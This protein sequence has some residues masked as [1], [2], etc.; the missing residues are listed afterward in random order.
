MAAQ[1]TGCAPTQVP[2]WQV[3]VRVQASASSQAVPSATAS[4]GMQVPVA[5]SQVLAVWHWSG[6]AGQTTGLVPT[7][8]PA[9]QVSVWVQASASSQAVP[10]AAALGV[11]QR[12]VATSHV[13]AVW[14]RSAVQ[15]TGLAPTQVPA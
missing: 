6:A 3:S 14:Q 12:P 4:E 8:V 15:T 1:P 2:T 5:A 7:Q 9:W 11:E 10:S 13:P